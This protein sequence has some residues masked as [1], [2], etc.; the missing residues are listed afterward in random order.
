MVKFRSS[1]IHFGLILYFFAAFMIFHVSQESIV[2]LAEGEATNVSASYQ[3]WELAYWTDDSNE[4]QV[5]ALDTKDFKPG[6]Q[7][8]LKRI[9]PSRLKILFKQRCL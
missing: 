4:R 6:F 5:T 2:H 1:I 7:F 3:D 9:L 8:L